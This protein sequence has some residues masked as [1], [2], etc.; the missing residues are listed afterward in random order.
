MVKI[1]IYLGSNQI[2]HCKF[3]YYAS[4]IS[5]VDALYCKNLFAI[6]F[7][8]VKWIGLDV[9]NF[10]SFTSPLQRNSTLNYVYF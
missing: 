3:T 9:P 2:V 10:T 6:T 8:F 1:Y 7:I 5:L 4:K